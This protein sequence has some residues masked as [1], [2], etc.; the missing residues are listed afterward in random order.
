MPGRFSNLLDKSALT[1]SGLCLLHCLAGT[2]LLT[3]FAAGSEWLDHDVH[4]IGF[5]LALPLA[6]V[7]LWRGVA[8]HGRFGVAA[9]GAL[10]IGLMALSLLIGHGGSGETLTSM[11]GVALLGL[12]HLWNLRAARGA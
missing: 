6:A 11:A 3:L 8:A 7:A 1:L 10:G 4:V 5:G 9:L 12:A 2:L